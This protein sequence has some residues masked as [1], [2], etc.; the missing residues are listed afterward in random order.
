MELYLNSIITDFHVS[1][2][3]MISTIALSVRIVDNLSIT[4][5]SRVYTLHPVPNVELFSRNRESNTGL[6]ADGLTDSA[7]GYNKSPEHTSLNWKLSD[8]AFIPHGVD[9]PGI[10]FRAV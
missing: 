3:D 7:K 2:K 6:P 5:M 10:R 9:S 4:D 1:R 8:A